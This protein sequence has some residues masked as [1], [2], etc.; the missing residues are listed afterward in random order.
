ME[1]IF[2]SYRQRWTTTWIHK[3]HNKEFLQRNKELTNQYEE[4]SQTNKK[5]RKKKMVKDLNSHF[6]KEGIQIANKLEKLLSLIGNE[7]NMN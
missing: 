3:L 2:N 5:Q 7:E 1:N 6:T 4:G